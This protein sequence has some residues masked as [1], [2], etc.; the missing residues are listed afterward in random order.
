ME[1]A[2]QLGDGWSRRKEGEAGEQTDTLIIIQNELG[3]VLRQQEQLC[4]LD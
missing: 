3:L 2:L 1:G 4:G